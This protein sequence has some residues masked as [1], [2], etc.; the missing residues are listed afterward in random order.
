[1]LGYPIIDVELTDV[2]FYTCFE[3]AIN[4]Y[5][6]QINLNITIFSNNP[7]Q[8]IP[9]KDI[10]FVGKRWIY[11]YFLANCKE[12]L[13]IIRRK[14]QTIPVSFAEITLDGKELIRE[15]SAEKERLIMKFKE[16]CKL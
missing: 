13:G 6:E 3:D 9:F 16:N 4:E 7:I 10:N 8:I 14:Y 12:I 1:M 15:A 5:N 2:H 11:K